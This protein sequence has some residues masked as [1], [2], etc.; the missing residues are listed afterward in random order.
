ML[1]GWRLAEDRVNEARRRTQEH[2]PRKHMLKREKNQIDVCLASC[3]AQPGA[4]YLC[5]A[6][7]RAYLARPLHGFGK[8]S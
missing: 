4:I 8:C 6:P 2:A 3:K 5:K 1:K 7:T